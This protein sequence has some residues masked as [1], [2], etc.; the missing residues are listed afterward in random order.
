[1][2]P[3]RTKKPWAVQNYRPAL[4]STSMLD[5]SAIAESNSNSDIRESPASTDTTVSTPDPQTSQPSRGPRLLSWIWNHGYLINECEWQ[6]IK[7]TQGGAAEPQ[8]YSTISTTHVGNHLRDIHQS[9]TSTERGKA[10]YASRNG[11]AEIFNKITPFKPTVFHT[12]L[13]EFILRDRISLSWK[14]KVHSSVTL[15]KVSDRK[16]L[17][18]SL[19]QQTQYENGHWIIT[20]LPKKSSKINCKTQ[21]QKFT[22]RVICG[23]LLMV[24]PSSVL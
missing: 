2:G 22:S 20:R 6:C 15:S 4:P 10:V 1:M 11:L 8:T 19:N 14:L 13:V 9:T 7:C 18:I 16:Q 12:A 21:C 5:S 3:H 17:I 24:M 23:H